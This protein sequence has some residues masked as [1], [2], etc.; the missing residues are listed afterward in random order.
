MR[1]IGRI[2]ALVFLVFAAV[3]TTSLACRVDAQDASEY[4]DLVRAY[5]DG[6]YGAVARLRTMEAAALAAA[7]DLAL[8]SGEAGLTRDAL[9]GAAMLHTDAWHRDLVD[10]RNTTVHLDIAERLLSRA[11][12]L[13]RSEIDY[14]RRWYEVAAGLARHLGTKGQAVDLRARGRTRYP[15]D[16]SQEKARRSF[17]L[18]M[19]IEHDGS[20]TGRTMSS[21][22]PARPALS[23]ELQLRWWTG[24]AAQ[25]EAALKADP[26]YR[27]AALHLGRVRMLQ[28]K[29]RD[30]ARLFED[31]SNSEDPRVAYLA[32]LFLGSLAEREGR[33]DEA[34]RQYRAGQQRYPVG[35]AAS[36]ALSQLL[37]RTARETEA[38]TVLDALLADGRA[39]RV[40]PLW[41]YLAPG[42]GLN[43]IMA[44]LYELRAEVMR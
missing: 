34:E 10:K 5:R 33:F 4:A 26:S 38:R 1:T 23:D 44:A 29:P 18:G 30:A 12:D 20:T 3:A 35:Q 16:P 27:M 41:T 43:D 8:S 6:N 25:Y 37:S 22:G 9:R 2:L 28:D 39:N 7:V 19:D 36:I 13:S 15:L 31:A 11:T 21:V 17:A 40:E 14:A 24:A 42:S 32:V